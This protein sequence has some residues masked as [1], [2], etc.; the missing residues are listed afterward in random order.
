MGAE[1]VV[2]IVNPPLSLAQATVVAGKLLVQH[3]VVSSVAALHSVDVV[4][5]RS[6]GAACCCNTLL[7]V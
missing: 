4:V 6:V 3:S 1:V 5:E 7:H 2:N